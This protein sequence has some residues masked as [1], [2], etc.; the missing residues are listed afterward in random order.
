MKMMIGYCEAPAL[1]LGMNQSRISVG[2]PSITEPIK[3]EG[4]KSSPS[5]PHCKHEYGSFSSSRNWMIST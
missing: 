4:I 3:M 5:C 1:G 2:A